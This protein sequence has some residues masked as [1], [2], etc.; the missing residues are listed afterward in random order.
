MTHNFL[1]R[2]DLMMKTVLRSQAS[3]IPAVA[4]RAERRWRRVL[5]PVGREP[6][7][8]LGQPPTYPRLWPSPW[9]RTR[10]E[11]GQGAISALLIFEPFPS[12]PLDGA[13]S[14][15]PCSVGTSVGVRRPRGAGPGRSNPGVVSRLAGAG[16]SLLPLAAGPQDHLS[17]LSFLG[18]RFGSS[19]CLRGGAP[20][21]P[22]GPAWP[23][24][25]H[26]R[27]QCA[28]PLQ[29]NPVFLFLKCS[30]LPPAPHLVLEGGAA[31][32]LALLSQESCWP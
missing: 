17:P 7:C 29:I 20:L 12:F 24:S 21:F 19:S 23:L 26:G 31:S 5:C 6:L 4:S 11:L 9:V 10:G 14:L 2:G 1:R 28:G 22:G 18:F 30:V 15:S 13:L 3:G 27:S 8:G 32:G 25:G 16:V